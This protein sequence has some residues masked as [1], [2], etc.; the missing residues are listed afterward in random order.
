[1]GYSMWFPRKV[2]DNG[3]YKVSVPISVVNEFEGRYI[4]DVMNTWDRIFSLHFPNFVKKMIWQYYLV[5]KDAQLYLS[6]SDKLRNDKRTVE[7]LYR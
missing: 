5:M 3:D 6:L 4:K 7:S 2:R 1:M